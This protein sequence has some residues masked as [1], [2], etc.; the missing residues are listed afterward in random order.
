MT[1]LPDTPGKRLRQMIN[2]RGLMLKEFASLCNC[3][4]STI[5]RIVNDK[6]PISPKLLE[7][8]S[9]VLHVSEDYILCKTD[10][11][12]ESSYHFSQETIDVSIQ[13]HRVSCAT[14]YL[15]SLHFNIIEKVVINNIEFYRSDNMMFYSDNSSE[16]LAV[17]GFIDEYS[18]PQLIEDIQCSP[19]VPAHVIDIS[20]EN[21]SKRIPYMEYVQLINSLC[22]LTKN[23]ILSHINK[24]NFAAYF[25]EE[26]DKAISEHARKIAQ[27][28]WQP[29]SKEEDEQRLLHA[30]YGENIPENPKKEE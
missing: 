12:E 23:H 14:A 30:I 21:I 2:R 8:F 11:R 26:L 29:P 4:S 15:S 3:T 10:G 16:E 22:E 13:A 20:Y 28:T 24:F 9:E 17:L 19:I 1:T 27:G 5:S 18:E 7:R 6:Y 25:P